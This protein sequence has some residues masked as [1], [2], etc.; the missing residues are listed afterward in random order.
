MSDLEKN[1]ETC[2][3]FLNHLAQL[4]IPAALDC[5]T[6]DVIWWVQGDWPNGNEHYGKA[7]IT[8]LF[9]HVKAILTGKLTFEFG[10]F[11][12]EA[13]RVAVEMHSHA[14]FRNGKTYNNTYHYL[15][16]IREGRIAMGKE[17][18]DTKHL[19]E[20]VFAA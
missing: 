5:V 17:Y 19:F 9:D 14:V 1:K 8:Q 18:L 20:T 12:A 10:A 16:T 15:F 11:T 7:G 2:R 6:D 3:R 13:D 4:D